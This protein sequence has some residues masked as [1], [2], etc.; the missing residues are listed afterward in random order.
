ME[1]HENEL[2]KNA[3]KDKEKRP[4]NCIGCKKNIYKMITIWNV[5]K[6]NQ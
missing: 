4:Q 3:H 5:K 2:T 1:Q 6:C